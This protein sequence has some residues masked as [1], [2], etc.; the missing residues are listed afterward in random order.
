MQCFF[1]FP[2][3]LKQCIESPKIISKKGTSL[4]GAMKCLI[5]FGS[6]NYD[7]RDLLIV[8]WKNCLKYQ[9]LHCPSLMS[10]ATSLYVQCTIWKYHKIKN[11]IQQTYS[12]L[13][14]GT[15]GQMSF[16]I[17]CN[18]VQSWNSPHDLTKKRRD[19]QSWWLRWS[20]VV[21][22]GNLPPPAPRNSRKPRPPYLL[23][24]TNSYEHMEKGLGT[25]G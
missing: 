12:L 19:F 21:K 20:N 18:L 17:K 7:V 16:K 5:L 13:F 11:W 8:K 9:T 15:E 1:T 22:H 23:L 3:L 10:W 24:D 14:Y 6:L 2:N 4:L 25:C